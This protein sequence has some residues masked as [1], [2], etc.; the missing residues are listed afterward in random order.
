MQQ[1][2]EM[3]EIG[4]QARHEGEL[5]SGSDTEDHHKEKSVDSEKDEQF[6]VQVHNHICLCLQF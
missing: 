2:G 6:R 4:R 1:A 5:Q 3:R